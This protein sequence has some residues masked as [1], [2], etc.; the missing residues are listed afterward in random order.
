VVNH[1]LPQH[2][3]SPSSAPATTLALEVSD[4]TGRRA[5]SRKLT[6]IAVLTARAATLERAG[7][8]PLRVVQAVSTDDDTIDQQEES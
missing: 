2:A 6:V 4:E 7:L 1:R 5:M 8:D 3:L